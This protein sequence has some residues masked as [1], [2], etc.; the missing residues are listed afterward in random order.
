MELKGRKIAI[1]ATHGFEQ[2]ELEVPRDTLEQ[3]GASVEIV[4][5]AAGEIRG[6]TTRIGGD[7]QG[8]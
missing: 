5:I 3:A 6:W 7:G 4:S 1:L 8:R 2:S